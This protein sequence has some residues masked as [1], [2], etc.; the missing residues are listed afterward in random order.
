MPTGLREDEPRK[1]RK[2]WQAR[3]R[4]HA[5]QRTL[6]PRTSPHQPQ[7]GLVGRHPRGGDRQKQAQRDSGKCGEEASASRT[8]QLAHDRCPRLT[9]VRARS[10]SF[11]LIATMTVL[12]DMKA[13]PSAGINNG[14]QA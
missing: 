14:P 8:I 6:L 13:A 10:N 5:F 11:A 4:D 2:R 12:S 1:G 9:S 7:K 3:Q